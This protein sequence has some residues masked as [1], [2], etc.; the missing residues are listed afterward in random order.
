MNV[1]WKEHFSHRTGNGRTNTASGSGC[2]PPTDKKSWKPAGP[3]EE[4]GSPYRM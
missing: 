2:Q 4:K 3:K 1:K